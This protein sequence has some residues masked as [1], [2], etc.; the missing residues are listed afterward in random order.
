MSIRFEFGGKYKFQT[1]KVDENGNDIEETRQ[2]ITGW[3][4]NIITDGGL[5]LF[6]TTP[7]IS[8]F[9]QCR[10]GSGSATPTAADTG[11]VAQ[12]ATTTTQQALT[13]G[14][15]GSSPYYGYIRKTFRFS[16][17]SAAGNL[18]EV[19]IFGGSGNN[20]CI[21]RALILDGLGDPTTITILSDEVLD[22]IYEFRVYA[23]E[24]DVSYGPVNISGT[25]YSGTIRAA[26]V[27]NPNITYSGQARPSGAWGNTG[28][29]GNIYGMFYGV[30]PYGVKLP[31]FSTQTLG[32]ITGN[33]SGTE[34]Y[35][36]SVTPSS[37]TSGSYYRNHE[38]LYDL[39]QG[40]IS[41]GIGSMV[42]GTVFG[43]F[44]MS[45]TPKIDKDVTKRL[46][47]NIRVSW[48]RY[49]P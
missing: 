8:T 19:G 27:N 43:T 48:G 36:T 22:V 39:N 16:I 3:F 17:G 5:D 49:T 11:L 4:N 6:G 14:V 31:V 32:S 23:P 44:Q 15:S 35:P 47:L 46:K 33:I 26:N 42:V 38:I 10:V 45:F 20:T 40:N 30:P 24:I 25:D 9:I 12:V 37:Y 21:S 29:W 7:P 28:G 41:G 13:N 2:D 18:S 34:Y 1:C